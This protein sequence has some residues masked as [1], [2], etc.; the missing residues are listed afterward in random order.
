M[1]KLLMVRILFCLLVNLENTNI[2]WILETLRLY[3]PVHSL[4]R[5][6]A[7]DYKIPDTEIIIPKKTKVLIP[8]Y[9]IHHDPD[10]YPE[11]EIFDPER[12]TPENI[13]SRHPFAYLPF[14]DGP[15]NCIGMRFAILEARIAL[16]ELLINYR[17]SVNDKT[18][19]DLKLDPREFVLSI[20][21]GIWLNAEKIWVNTNNIAFM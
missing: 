8:V 2:L 7:E 11:P 21:D 16:S 14:G 10:I 19:K 5:Q 9:A 3:D 1:A 12:F 17:F 18:E 4:I 13:K 6:A 20:R 15:R